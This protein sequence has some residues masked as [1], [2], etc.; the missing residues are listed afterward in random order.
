M[1]VSEVGRTTR[2]SGSSAAGCSEPSGALLEPV[3]RDH[4]HLLGEAL[5]VLR[6][7]LEV[8]QRDEE[9]EVGVH[10]A[11]LLDRV[12]EGALHQLPDPVAP[13][14]DHHAPADVVELRDL[15]VAH[16]ALEPLREVLSASGGD[17]G[18][19]LAFH[20][21]ARWVSPPRTI[22][23]HGAAQG[24][25]APV[26][27]GPLGPAAPADPTG[28]AA[29]SLDDPER[30]RLHPP[31]RAARLPRDRVLLGRRAR[32]LRRRRSSG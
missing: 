8:A 31:R 30:R 13:G 1:I 7:L 29:S 20:I 16:D 3:V 26:R 12:V 2:G 10:R 9:R 18:F 27:A 17:P 11:G 23:A 21:L 19:R 28:P 15:G 6:L 25:P 24:L 32:R 22:L 14:T 4:R 5:D